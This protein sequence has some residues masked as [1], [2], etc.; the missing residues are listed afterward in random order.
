MLLLLN[1]TKTMDTGAPVPP[2]LKGTE[3]Y[4]LEQAIRLA[5]KISRMSRSRLA[6]MMSLSEK[7]TAETHSNAAQWGLKNRPRIPALFGFTGLFYKSLDALTLDE[8]Q[9]RDA[10]KRIR[11]LSGLYGMLRPFDLIEAYRLE[12]AH[13]LVPGRTKNMAAFWKE[14]LTDELNKDLKV[15]EPIISVASQEYMKALNLNK[16]NGP[17]ISP[18]F[19]E[20]HVN[21]TY[22]TVGVHSK[23][24][25][26]ELVR[27]VLVN[28]AQTPRDLMGFNAMGWRPAEE[29]PVEGPW[30]FTR[31]VTT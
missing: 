7:L 2:R 1:T 3:P 29:V 17:V 21:G 27:Y 12:M 14:T 22:K 26:G 25:R 18:V 23:K 8:V 20:Q 4:H 31:P 15:G 10:Q 13:K 28:K 6:E 19:K 11:I 30:L 5:G 16:L 9:L 24:A